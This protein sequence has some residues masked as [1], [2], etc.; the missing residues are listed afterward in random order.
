MIQDIQKEDPKDLPDGIIFRK[1]QVEVDSSGKT[2]H[3]GSMP[4]ERI[5]EI[6]NQSI[7]I[8]N[9]EKLPL[10]IRVAIFHYLFGYIHPFYEGNGRMSRFISSAYL[11]KTLDILC[12][13]QSSISCK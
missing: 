2:I 6:M 9:D 5:I 3:E 13:L 8:L 10:L 7:Q 12:A 4:E 1:N 11:C